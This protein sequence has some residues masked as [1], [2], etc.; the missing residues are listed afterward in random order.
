MTGARKFGWPNDTRDDS[1]A[2]HGRAGIFRR[3]EKIR[4]AGLFVGEKRVAG[5]VYAQRSGDQIRR[6][7]QHISVLSNPRDFPC[8]LE[9]S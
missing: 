5:L 3:N 7:R 6:V 4:L 1:V 2:V 9:F 8:L